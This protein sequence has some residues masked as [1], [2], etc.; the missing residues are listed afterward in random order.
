VLSSL[1][2][3]FR[4]KTVAMDHGPSLPRPGRADTDSVINVHA[5]LD[6]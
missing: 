6:D 2:A 1:F 3:V 4:S 5:M